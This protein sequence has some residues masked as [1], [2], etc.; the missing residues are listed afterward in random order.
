MPGF[1]QRGPMNNGPMTGG[2]RG[3][4]TGNIT[5]GQG[6]AGGGYTMGRGLGRRGRQNSGWR[7][8]QGNGWAG[9]AP[10]VSTQVILQNRA[11]M[12]EAELTEIKNQLNKLNESGE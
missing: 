9:P 11:D 1:N 8:G 2:G 4:C 12:L 3:S 6:F 7:S 10:T 5:P